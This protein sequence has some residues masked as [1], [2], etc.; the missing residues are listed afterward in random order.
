[1]KQTIG[2]ERK[3]ECLFS[4]SMALM[5]LMIILVYRQKSRSVKTLDITVSF[6]GFGFCNKETFFSI[7]E[8]KKSH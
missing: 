8:A 7:L 1:M 5:I 3:H 4:S 2:S 6:I